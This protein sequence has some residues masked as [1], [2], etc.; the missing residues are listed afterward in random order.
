MYLLAYM[1]FPDEE[2]AKRVAE[3]LVADKLAAG[4]NMLPG[5][6]SVYRWRGDIRR[7]MEWLLLAQTTAECWDKFQTLAKRMHPDHVPCIVA[8]P[9]AEGDP[10][11]LEWIKQNT[12]AG[13]SCKLP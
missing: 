7:R 4:V 6:A 11:F 2:S 1:T 10:A 12:D 8:C 9:F 5:V 3:A 13:G